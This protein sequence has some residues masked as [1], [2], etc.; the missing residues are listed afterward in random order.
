MSEPRLSNSQCGGTPQLAYLSSCK[1]IQL[2]RCRA[3]DLVLTSFSS[4]ANCQTMMRAED[5]DFA[6]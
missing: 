6:V 5:E 2:Y 1:A 3:S 4:V